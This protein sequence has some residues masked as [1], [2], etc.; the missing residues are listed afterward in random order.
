M[1]SG[2]ISRLAIIATLAPLFFF[3]TN[4]ISQA[5]TTDCTLLGGSKCEITFSYTGAPETFTVPSGITSIY[6]DVR[7]AQGGTSSTSQLGGQGGIDTGTM[8]VTPG[9]NLIIYVGGAGTA[10]TAALTGGFNGGGGTNSSSAAPGTGG[11]ASDIRLN[12]DTL[13]AR[14]VV[15]GGGGGGD[16]Y[17][18]PGGGGAGGGLTGGNGFA[19]YC[20]SAGLGGTQTAGG[21]MN[22]GTCGYRNDTKGFF[23]LGGRGQGY[24]DG[25]GGG[26]G[27]WY[28]GSGGV[29]AGGGGGSSRVDTSVVTS[30]SLVRGGRL[31]NGL[32]ILSYLVPQPT[33]VSFTAGLNATF[34]SS[35]TITISSNSP[36]KANFYASGKII[37]GCRSVTT[38]S[39]SSPYIYNCT[40]K[41]SQR[42]GVSISATVIPNNGN[43][44]G[45]SSATSSVTT[46]TTTR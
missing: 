25:G 43:L 26:G 46:R 9:S 27:G 45:N 34:R 11:G 13:T 5:A 22:L 3:S 20:N 2:W 38:A 33:A 15:A 17:S 19:S 37:P 1:K 18:N 41:P 39:S 23:G 29:I 40:W 6:F 14:V 21:A 8:T 32:V 12:A 10:A 30:Y 35:T 24:S 36:G 4:A 44:V 16:N 31:G 42:G 28:G 7:G